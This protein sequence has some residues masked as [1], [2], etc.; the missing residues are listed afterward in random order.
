[1]T[2]WTDRLR[3][4]PRRT[5]AALFLL[6]TLLGACLAFTPRTGTDTLAEMRILAS[7]TRTYCTALLGPDNGISLYLESQDIPEIAQSAERDH[8]VAA[9]LPL[10]PALVGCWLGAKQPL[11][12]FLWR[13]YT[14]LLV[15]AGAGALYCLARFLLGG[16]RWALAAVGLFL[17]YP[18]L[19]GD[20]LVNNKDLALLSFMLLSLWFGLRFVEKARWRD[21]LLFGALA[22]FAANARILGLLPFGLAGLLYLIRLTLGRRWSLPAFFKGAAAMGMFWL[23]WLAITPA[24]WSGVWRQ[25]AYVAQASASFSRWQGFVLFRGQLLAPLYQG[26]PW[27]YL[28]V[29]FAISVPLITLCLGLAGHGTVLRGMFRRRGGFLMGQNAWWAILLL[30]LW[31]PVLYAVA[32][33]M[34]LYNSWRHFYFIYGFWV[35]LAAHALRALAGRGRAGRRG[36]FTLIAVQ[37]A[38]NLTFV[39]FSYPY[40]NAYFSPVAAPFVQDRYE[41]D[42][43]GEGMLPCALQ[44]AELEYS[45]QPLVVAGGDNATRHRLPNELIALWEGGARL[46]PL[47]LEDYGPTA[48]TTQADYWIVNEN[49]AAAPRLGGVSGVYGEENAQSANW[50][51]NLATGR[52]RELF[53]VYS[54]PVRLYTVYETLPQHTSD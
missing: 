53:A 42:Y 22:A 36:A 49:Y 30:C 12:H 37:L 44:L 18:R 10:G 20:S 7:N 48:E 19:L 2:H 25:I 32:T 43:W 51:L 33:G 9:Y 11:L 3:R 50:Q 39:G 54:G 52:Y 40:Y 1:M 27:T 46:A 13:F 24:A 23:S 5:V 31:L 14:Y 15:L 28:P 17:F 21:A 26:L 6:L 41:T 38:A 8:G 47:P 29:C 34:V 35:L 45:G 4:R 16:R